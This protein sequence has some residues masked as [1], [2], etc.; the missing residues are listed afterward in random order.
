MA[1]WKRSKNVLD[2]SSQSVI[3]Y[4]HSTTGDNM[5]DTIEKC[6]YVSSDRLH[7]SKPMTMYQALRFA[8]SLEKQGHK[9]VFFYKGQ[10]AI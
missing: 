7:E 10:L 5:L 6:Y 2:F 8:D 1:L 9:N 4:R 3:L